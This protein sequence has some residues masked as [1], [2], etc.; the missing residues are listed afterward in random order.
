MSTTSSRST[1]ALRLSLS[2]GTVLNNT[3]YSARRPS[4]DGYPF[5]WGLGF[6]TQEDA[7]SNRT[8]FEEAARFGIRCGLTIPVH[9]ATGA[10]AAITFAADIPRPQF[11]RMVEAHACVLQIMAMYFLAH[12]SRK[13]ASSRSVNGISLSPRERECLKWA[14]EGKSAW[15]TGE[16]IGISQHTVTFHLKNAKAKLGVRSSIPAV[17]RLARAN[18][19]V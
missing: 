11:E 3:P 13:L 14:A 15:Q 19:S 8:V 18:P 5:S 16:I 2:I 12:A 1:W 9:D 4:P 17:A 7:D 10:I 6:K